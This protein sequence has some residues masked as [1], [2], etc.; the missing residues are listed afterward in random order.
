VSEDRRERVAHA[1]GHAIRRAR[2]RLGLSM[3]DVAGKA[4][5]SQPFLSDLEN[6]RAMPSITTL[7]RLADTFDLTPQDLL[8]A[9]QGDDVVVVRA[10]SETRP[11]D[12]SPGVAMSLLVAG[13]P[14]RLMEVRR[15]QLA[16][17]LPVGDW[18]E[19]EGEDLLF[20]VRGALRI[21][22]DTGLEERLGAGDALWHSGLIP[23]R[24]RSEPGRS[25]ELLLVKGRPP[26]TPRTDDHE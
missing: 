17:D 12:G 1:L 6:G 9:L 2:A 5:V 23:H 19:H 7:Y 20:L 11:V 15:Y 24:W 14:G 8:P 4:G 3:R 21:E 26:V 22:F 16:S 10:G 25:A 13:G 18:Y